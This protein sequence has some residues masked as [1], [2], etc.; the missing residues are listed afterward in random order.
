MN[1]NTTPTGEPRIDRVLATL[2]SVATGGGVGIITTDH[3]L[4][5]AAA[6]L[7]DLAAE[8][9]ARRAEAE[10]SE[11][12]LMELLDVISGMAALDFSRSATV[13]EQNTLLDVLATSLNTLNEELAASVVSKSYVDNIIESMD[14]TLMVLN[15]DNTIRTANRALC[16]LLGYE[17][18]EL[19]G[20]PATLILEDPDGPTVELMQI[21]MKGQIRNRE[22]TYR[23]KEGYFV[24][25]LFSASLM[26]G[27]RN[28]PVGL[29]CVARDITEHKQTE[30]ALRRTA[31]QEELIKAQAAMLRELSTPL[32]P[33]DTRAVVM[34]LIGTIDNGRAQQIV[35]V[36][37]REVSRRRTDVAILDITGVAVVD[38]QVADALLRAARAVRLLGAQAII[39]GIR[40]EV[41]QTLVGLGVDMTGII[42]HRTLQS[43]I[44]AVMRGR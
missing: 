44:A 35:E 8:L 33:I 39:T 22:T 32:I 14:D 31:V 40:P 10:R 5:H 4:D 43:G 24:P 16:D 28:E 19:T 17:R 9:L 21:F 3:T 30:E 34:P 20:R 36:L 38:T 42:T 27:E 15:P 23:A 37:L 1:V 6:E 41:A 12:R 7:R 25:M 29:V 26:R 11:T 13:G 2:A 18:D